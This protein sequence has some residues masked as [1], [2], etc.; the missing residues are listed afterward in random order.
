MQYLFIDV[1]TLYTYQ[2][3]FK[4]IIKAFVGIDTDLDFD[5]FIDDADYGRQFVTFIMYT[6]T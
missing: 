3:R 6:R 1:N 2:R 4:N 5:I